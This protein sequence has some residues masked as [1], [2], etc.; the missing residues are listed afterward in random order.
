MATS[1]ALNVRYIFN[2]LYTSSQIFIV[3][4]LN[5]NFSKFFLVIK[6]KNRTVFFFT[7]LK[8]ISSIPYKTLPLFSSPSFPLFCHFSKIPSRNESFHHLFSL[9]QGWRLF[10]YRFC[11]VCL[12]TSF[13]LSIIFYS[14]KRNCLLRKNIPCVC[15]QKPRLKRYLSNEMTQLST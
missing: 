6:K 3:Y 9:S 2:I 12:I 11:C 14:F 15:I 8:S 10:Y 13:S 4:F 1:R 5:L 7:L